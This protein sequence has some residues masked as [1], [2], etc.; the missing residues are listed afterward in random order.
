MNKMPEE[1]RK[2]LKSYAKAQIRTRQLYRQVVEEIERYN[3]PIDNLL[4]CANTSADFPQTEALAY[5]NNGECDNLQELIEDI[6]E[7]FLWFVNNQDS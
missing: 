6:E 3:V 2:A 5:I 4:A 7:V 1:L